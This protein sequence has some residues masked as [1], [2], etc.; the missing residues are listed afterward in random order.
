MTIEI[1]IKLETDELKEL[2]KNGSELIAFILSQHDN[3]A[4]QLVD[5]N[6]EVT[7]AKINKKRA[8]K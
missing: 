4:T 3:L 6:S 5:S 1:T 8:K 7:V 2:E